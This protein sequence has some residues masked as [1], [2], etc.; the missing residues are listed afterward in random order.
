MRAFAHHELGI[1]MFTTLSA[2]AQP[3]KVF[4]SVLSEIP[5][6]RKD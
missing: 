4:S 5:I 3:L 2:R 1:H 6:L